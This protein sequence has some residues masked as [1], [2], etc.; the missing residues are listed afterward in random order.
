MADDVKHPFWI[1]W[2]MTE[3]TGAFT[4]ENPWWISGVRVSD[5]AESV[6]A[7]V[8]AADEEDAMRVIL[9]AHDNPKTDLEWRF[10]EQREDGWAP[11]SSRF[12]R[13]EWMRWP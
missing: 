11:F 5:E 3:S 7:A 6:C 2:W 1:S 12:Q 8:M 4:L 13:V 10:V 9:A